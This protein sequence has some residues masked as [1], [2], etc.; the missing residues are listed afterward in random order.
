[1]KQAT[2]TLTTTTASAQAIGEGY[3]DEAIVSRSYEISGTAFYGDGDTQKLFAVGET[4]YATYY[5]QS[6]NAGSLDQ[7]LF[8]GNVV[9]TKVSDSQTQGEYETQDI[10]VKSTGTPVKPPYA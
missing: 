5:S 8:E 9:V 1:V 2:L 6:T 4:C 3:A 10:T 7:V